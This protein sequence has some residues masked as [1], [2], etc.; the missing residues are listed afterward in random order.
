MQGD[1]AP[2]PER[3][4]WAFISYNQ[5][6]RAWAEWLHKSLETYRIPRRLVGSAGGAAHRTPVPQRLYPVFRDRDEL[7]GAASLGNELEGALKA[8]HTLVVICS[9]EATASRWVGEE[10]K[11]FKAMG[12]EDRVLSLVVDGEPNVSANPAKAAAECFPE[13]LRFRVDAKGRITSEP[14]EPIAADVRPQGDGKRSA[15]LKLVAGIAKLPYDALRQRD[16]ER[17]TKRMVT[18]LL[19]MAGLVVVFAGL[20]IYA[21]QQ[22]LEAEMRGRIALSRQLSAQADYRLDNDL[23]LSLLLGAQATQVAETYE[24]RSVLFNALARRAAAFLPSSEKKIHCLAFSPDDRLLASGCG[25][26]TV[27]LWDTESRRAVGTVAVDKTIEFMNDKPKVL[28]LGFGAGGKRLSAATDEGVIQSWDV[29]NPRDLAAAKAER[30]PFNAFSGLLDAI[31]SAEFSEGGA[32][33]AFGSEHGGILIWDMAGHKPIG[34]TL[35]S[36]HAL[37]EALAFSRDGKLLAAAGVGPT[38]ALWDVASQARSG[39][40]TTGQTNRVTALAFDPAGE[41]IASGGLDNAIEFWNVKA[42]SRRGLRDTGHRIGSQA[43]PSARMGGG[44]RRQA[45]IA[46]SC[47]G[48]TAG[49]CRTCCSATETASGRS[50]SATTEACWRRPPT[51]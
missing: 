23:D 20:A 1:E 32:M 41:V 2:P 33:A 3:K 40:I 25:S 24:A 44:S 37:I 36:S 18:G 50:R 11:A 9:P 4:Y 26:D 5:R 28:A 30:E 21:N 22:R 17:R 19:A 42:Q 34:G 6:D 46:R 13:A 12:R 43:L 29:T 27:T 47:C 7:S 16:H 38:I 8:S 15:L 49:R 31:T 51:G 35:E 45:W 39:S 14:T 10:I 48:T